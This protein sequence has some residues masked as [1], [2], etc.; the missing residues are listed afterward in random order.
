MLLAAHHDAY[1][2]SGTDDTSCVA[3]NLA[4]AKAM[5]QS[6]Y[7]PNY[8]VRFMFDTGE[9]FGYTTPTTTGASAPGMRSL[10]AIPVG[11]ARSVSS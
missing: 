2:H 6:N 4:I 9:E 8:T 1:F 10:T 7:R 11:R 3:N 5:V